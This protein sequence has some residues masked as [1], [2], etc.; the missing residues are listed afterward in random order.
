MRE[1]REKE[2]SREENKGLS[3]TNRTERRIAR[4]V[5]TYRNEIYER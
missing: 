1:R 4:D 2:L 3:M 5:M